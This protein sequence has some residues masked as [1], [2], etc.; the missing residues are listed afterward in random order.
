MNDPHLAPD[1]LRALTTRRSV[2]PTALGAPGPDSRQLR[3]LL[4][5]A[6]RVPDHG[7]LAPW[8]LILLEGEARVQVGEGLGAIFREE[9]PRPDQAGRDKWAGIIARQFLHAPVVVIVVSRPDRTTKIPPSE[10]ELSAGALCMNILHGAHALGFGATW[11][12]G[13]ATTNARALALFGLGDGE[14][15]AGI[16][17]IGTVRE[18]PSERPRPDLDAVLTR[19]TP[20][21]SS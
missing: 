6:L 3:A 7:A 9:G 14:Q 19:W 13:W 10:Q 11:V 8:R 18:A 16:V 12:T 17:H 21:G 4:E 20:A 2:P 1:P 15:V 5:A